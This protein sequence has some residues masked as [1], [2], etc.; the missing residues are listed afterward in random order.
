MS[1]TL[2]PL[3][4]APHVSAAV[5]PVVP[6]PATVLTVF[7][8][9]G[10]ME[11]ELQGSLCSAPNNCQRVDQFLWDPSGL[12]TIDATIDATP[13]TKVVFSCS[14]GAR[15]VTR[16]LNKHAGD[17]DA[18]SPDELSFVMIGNPT[19][20]YG[21]SDSDVMPE[22]QYRVIDIT[23]QYDMASDFPDN[24]LNLIAL[25]NS[26]AAFT[27][28]HTDYENVD[29]YDD[30]NIV[31]EEGNITYVFV[32]TENLPLLEPLRQLGLTSLADALNEPLKKIVE[33][34]YDRSYLP[35]PESAPADPPT[36]SSAVAS[37]EVAAIAEQKWGRRGAGRAGSVTMSTVAAASESSADDDTH[38]E[39]RPALRGR[40][41]T[42]SSI[43]EDEKV[44]AQGPVE[45]LEAEST[46]D[47]TADHDED[48]DPA[49]RAGSRKGGPT[50]AADDGER[51]STD[52]DSRDDN[53]DT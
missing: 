41:T 51:A 8:W 9:E 38:V 46:T 48:A 34:G 18:P 39:D 7:P 26:L 21:G 2:V 22:T 3:V 23:R 50:A 19:R 28:I 35:A 31:W 45:S 12:A 24:P 44:A 43:S 16:W 13:G 29:M 20:R 49:V 32:P 47:L 5:V 42:K 40:K 27:V 25:L 53:S 4:A 36:P 17:A 30:A 15:S 14:E 37:H 52:D 6:S 10:S 11:D 1:A 33:R